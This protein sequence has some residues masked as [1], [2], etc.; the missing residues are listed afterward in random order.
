[1]ATDYLSGNKLIAGPVSTEQVDLAADVY[2]RGMPLKYGSTPVATGPVTGN[3]TCTVL[4]AAAGVKSGAWTLVFSAALVADLKDP[5]GTIVGTY[6]IIAGIGSE[7]VIEYK[8]LR[9][10]IKVGATAFAGTTIWTITVPSAGTYAYTAVGPF[11]AFYNG[12]TKTL[13]SAGFGSVVTA[14]E[15]YEGGIVDGSG[16]ALTITDAMRADMRAAGFAPKQ[17]G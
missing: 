10:T 6:A 16:D 17:V 7:T 4:S 3:G 9:F 15:I 13:A 5:A 2:Y 1:M 12:A 8:G 14:G 11:D